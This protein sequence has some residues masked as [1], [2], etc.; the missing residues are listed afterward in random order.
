PIEQAVLWRMLE[1]GTRFRPYDADALQF[2]NDK[3]G[4]KVTVAKAQKALEGLRAHQPSLIWKSVRSEYAVE[5]ATMLRWYAQRVAAGTW[6]PVGPQLDW[7]E[8]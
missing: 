5:D 6:P 8:E 2:Y 7:L 4:D 1:L 3:T